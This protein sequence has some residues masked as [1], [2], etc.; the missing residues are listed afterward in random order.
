[1]ASNKFS[2][3]LAN[4]CWKLLEDEFH[5]KLFAFDKVRFNQLLLYTKF[6]SSLFIFSLEFHIATMLLIQSNWYF[7]DISTHQYIT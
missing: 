6:D 4:R 5:K 1:M 7:L 2:Y 3:A